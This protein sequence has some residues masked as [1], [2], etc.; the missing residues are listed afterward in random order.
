MYADTDSIHCHDVTADDIKG[1]PRHA[2][3]FNYWK[4]EASWDDA[5]FVRQKTYVEH[6]VEENLEAI[7][8]PYFNI[9]CAGMGEGP[10]QNLT[11]WLNDGYKKVSE[12]DE[13]YITPFGLSDFKVGLAVEGNLKA[14]IVSGGT[15]LVENVY[16]MR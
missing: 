1:A 13:V 11:R 10:R 2:T 12:A 4:Y 5:I 15:V 9:K 7:D 6:V 14:K 8:E 3:A 16:K